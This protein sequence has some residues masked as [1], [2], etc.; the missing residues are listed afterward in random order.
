MALFLFYDFSGGFILLN[1]ISL[2][3]LV[4]PAWT[5]ALA[6]PARNWPPV[7]VLTALLPALI[8][9]QASLVAALVAEEE[10]ALRSYWRGVWAYWAPFLRLA[11]FFG[12]AGSVAGLGAW[13]YL[14]HVAL[15]RP[16]AGYAL[17]GICLGTAGL[18]A[19]SAMFCV[20]A[21]IHQRGSLRN[22]MRISLALVAG[23][24]VLALGLLLSVMAWT[25][26]LATPPGM[27][28]L[29][30]W[31]VVALLSCAYELLARAYALDEA[32][33]RGEVPPAGTLDEDDIFLNR[34]FT[35]LLFPWKA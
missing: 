34:G 35:D 23:H 10:F 4:L 21:L 30:T 12:A 7:I 13:F 27:L 29:F 25:L 33:A 9:G 20:P 28:L 15:S 24:P 1:A 2:A 8:A 19:L 22:S 32:L 14:A 16:V 18:L 11:A 17:A 3:A 26:V 5:L 31:P 6:F